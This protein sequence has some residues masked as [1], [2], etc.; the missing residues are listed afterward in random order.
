[1]ATGSEQ[2]VVRRSMSGVTLYTVHFLCC[3]GYGYT[4]DC[5]LH[6]VAG[7]AYFMRS[8]MHKIFLSG[9]MG[10]MT[11]G[12]LPLLERNMDMCVLKPLTQGLMT[13][14]AEVFLVLD[15]KFRMF[16]AVGIM[17]IGTYSLSD[18][19]VHK[20]LIQRFFHFFMTA[21]TEGGYLLFYQPFHIPC[22]RVMTGCAFPFP[23]RK[24]DLLPEKLVLHLGVALVAH[25]GDIIL[26]GGFCICKPGYQ[27]ENK[28]KDKNT[29]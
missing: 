27:S 19:I 10:F 12:A 21:K 13:I 24:M 3:T 9:C 22:M 8:R 23:E 6:R 11:G 26:Q 29:V 15:Q 28:N 1:V 2:S 16:S 5:T 7:F 20:F 25:A 14:P 18:R 4:I 17:T